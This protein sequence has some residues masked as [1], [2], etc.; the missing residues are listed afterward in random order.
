MTTSEIERSLLGSLHAYVKEIEIPNNEDDLL[1][2]ASSI[3]T[4]QLK[5]ANKSLPPNLAEL[6]T[7]Q[8]V[9]QFN[10]NA[11]FNSVINSATKEFVGKANEWRHS[12]ENQV[13]ETLNAF[14]QKFKPQ[15]I[16]NLSETILSIIPLVESV[17]LGKFQVESLI[18][19][20]IKEFDLNTA[21]GQIIGKDTLAIAQKLADF[22]QFG[23]VEQELL[24]A[25]LDGKPLINQTLENVTESL[26]NSELQK[27]IGNDSVQFDIDLMVRK[28]TLKINIM[29][30][31]TPP[32]KSAEEIAN[33]VDD[34]IKRFL[35][36]REK[37]SGVLNLFQSK[38]FLD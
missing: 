16:T 26:I 37:N 29:Q 20:V 14:V 23:N 30:A 18:Q 21:L 9:N 6:L 3:L 17:L 31:S 22:L 25:V 13:L 11:V 27:I 35:V 28:V 24:K 12:L 15:G 36:E 33:E 7:Q 2:I 38:I 19:K 4:F 1:A 8:V 5:Q 34:E 32:F 10:A